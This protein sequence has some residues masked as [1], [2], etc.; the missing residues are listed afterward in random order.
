MNA[1]RWRQIEQLYHS[2]RELDGDERDRF[3]K[4]AGGGDEELRQEVESLL[5]YETE[6]ATLLDRPAL[7]I[8]AKALAADRR[9]GMIGRTLGHYKV[10]S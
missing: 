9:S 5:S 1:Q 7:E 10:E 8:A 6:T 3:L 2:A 4:Q